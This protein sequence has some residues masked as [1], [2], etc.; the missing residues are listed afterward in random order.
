M[1]RI[2]KMVPRAESSSGATGGSPTGSIG[3]YGDTSGPR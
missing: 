2:T 1:R 3:E